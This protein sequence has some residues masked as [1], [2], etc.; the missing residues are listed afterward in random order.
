MNDIKNLKIVVD[1]ARRFLIKN[2]NRHDLI[3]IDLF[4]SGEI[5]FHLATQE[6]FQLV[7][8]HLTDQGIAVMNIYD[9]SPDGK[10]VKPLLNT[11]ASVFP[12]TYEVDATLGSYLAMGSK[13]PLEEAA[14]NLKPD[15][16]KGFGDVIRHFKNNF[17][18]IDFNPKLLVFTD[19]KSAIERLS[20]ESIFR[21]L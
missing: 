10:I 16:N 4:L 21:N 12:N 6:F 9:P 14:L 7:R 19:D 3:E 15:L 2:S 11:I 5:P 18:R 13:F 20:Y 17:E 8:D 1:D